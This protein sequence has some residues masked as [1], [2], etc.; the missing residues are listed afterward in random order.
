[1]AILSK[2]RERSMFLIVIIGLALFAFV[3]D[4]STIQDFFNSSKV[5]E[6]GNVDGEVISRQEFALALDAYKQQTGGRVSEMQAA[7]TVWN[8]LVRQ[9]IYQKQLAEA[10]ITVGDNDI[11]N[12]IY[13]N[14]SIQ[15]DARFQ[16][17]GIFDKN[18]VKEHLATIKENQTP[19]WK[20]WQTFMSSIKANLEK[21]AYDNL[22]AAGLGASLKEGELNYMSENTKMD[23]KFVYV[24][25]TTITDSLVSVS[26]GDIQAY[27][28]K[29]KNEFEV[30]A[31]RDI[32]FVKF[33]IKPTAE[34][35]EA[36]K[37]DLAK[38]LVD[39]KAATN[40]IE[41]FE[42][43]ESDLQLNDNYQ[44][45]SE[46][47]QVIAEEIFAGKVGDAFGAYKDGN[48]LKISKIT[49]VTQLPDSVK[50]SH[51][52]VPFLG[53]QAANAETVKTDAQAK[54]TIDSLFTLVKGNANKF[55]EVADLI[56]T[57]G[58][59]GKGGD[60]GWTSHKTAF[61]NYFDR[62]FA[63]YIFKNK[64][65]DVQVIKTKFGYHIIKID[66][67]KNFQPVVK[68]VTF[69]KE[70]VASKATEDD[71]FKKAKT[72]SQELTQGK[73]Y[74]ELVKAGN[75]NSLPA[76]GLKG[77]D[78][79]VPGVGQEREIITWAFE[80]DNEKGNFKQFEIDGGYVVAVLT[81]KTEKGLMPVAKAT[82]RVRPILIKEKKAKLLEDKMNGANLD[83]IAKASSQTV[84]T[85][86]K[87]NLQSPTISGV[88][89]EPKVVG[90][91]LN[92]KENEV[93]KNIVG[94]KGVFA[95]VITGKELPTA[96]P[97]YD[98][99]RKQLTNQR[100]N[101]KFQMYEAIKKASDIEDNVGVYYGI[102]E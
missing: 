48:H 77:L 33:D 7:K 29:H 99:F 65:G 9:K 70:I 88:G 57:D 38:T 20:S 71:V 59:K 32:K 41:F 87:V 80:A 86:S 60:I 85:A 100:Q 18:K 66:D 27:I 16:T 22:V 4:P 43:N 58:S 90:A 76:V 8:N 56:N 6:I 35:E 55:K 95:F 47:P 3:L 98:T 2:I 96:L 28:A 34:D 26:N 67:Q 68:L 61:S 15:N 12:A 24:P 19:E 5:N 40:D 69:G 84:R 75:L 42:E 94:D 1:M 78:E 101:K 10:G 93:Y 25:Y 11:L 89:N 30:E 44:Y 37:A 72:F 62:D 63:N 23:A 31:S 52:L 21:T 53:S 79:N 92:A 102:E 45:K 82:G 46:V 17:A 83:E 74:N 49:E 13:E 39:F 64:K 73:D 91:M 36:I 97:N 14:G 51:I 50:S 54:V 81:N